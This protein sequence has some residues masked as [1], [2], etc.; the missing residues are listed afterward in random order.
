MFEFKRYFS[1]IL[2]IFLVLF[3]VSC[4]SLKAPYQPDAEWIPP[5]DN[6]ASKAYDSEWI[7]LRNKKLG[8][9]GPLNLNELIEIAIEN[10]PSTRS[11][12]QNAKAQEAAKIQ[13][14]SQWYPQISASGNYTR[15][16]KD[17]TQKANDI[18]SKSYGGGSQVSWLILDFGERDANSRAA[19]YSLLA[20]NFEF[21]QAIQDLILEVEISYYTLYSA[22]ARLEASQMT[23]QDA[24]VTFH[25]AKQR[26]AVGLAAKLDVLQAESDYDEALFALEDSKDEVESARA[27]LANALGFPADTEF[28]IA[29]PIWKEPSHIAEKDVYQFI[30]EALEKRPD[31]AASRATLLAKEAAVIAA[32]SALFP[33]LSL[34]GS[35]DKTW[36]KNFVDVT[37][38]QRDY[39]YAGFLEIQWDVFDGFSNYAQKKQAQAEA[40]GQRQSLI[41]D[42]LALAA[43][44]WTKY[45]A[46]EASLGK[47]K[48][49]Q[50]FLQA[51]KESYDLALEGYRAGLKSILDLINAQ[52]NLA[53]ARSSLVQSKKDVLV[54]FA[55]LQHATGSLNLKDYE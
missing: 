49:S 41:Q 15:S 14:D 21:N 12:W 1:V 8:S 11:A 44:V 33:N 4:S 6:K 24:Q 46:Y 28:K 38:K 54:A 27:A 32:N 22:K 19:H 39:E 13:A 23:A 42:E 37:T 43:D 9:S 25:S 26:L 40:E 47:L 20:A 29:Q 17:S 10:N 18:D 48:Y 45:Y 3:N 53:A 52:D 55:Q 51:S 50:A 36:S 34:G 35:A 16:R 30:E 5:K 7:V 31:I 2:I